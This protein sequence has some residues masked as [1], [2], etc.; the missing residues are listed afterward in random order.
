MTKLF[1][2]PSKLLLLLLSLSFRHFH[3]HGEEPQCTDKDP[4]DKAYYTCDDNK[5]VSCPEGE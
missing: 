1:D 4:A 2:H 3:I 5:E